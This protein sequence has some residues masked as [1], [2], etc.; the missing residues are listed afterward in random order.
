MS[1][2]DE[3]IEAAL[4]DRLSIDKTEIDSNPVCRGLR[5]DSKKRYIKIWGFWKAYCSEDHA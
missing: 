1:T 2:A 4:R 5:K 3:Q